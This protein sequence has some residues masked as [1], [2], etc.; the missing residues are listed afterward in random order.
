MGKAWTK[1][2]TKKKE[3]NRRYTRIFADK[4]GKG[5]LVK[6]VRGCLRAVF[7]YGVVRRGVMAA[8]S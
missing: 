7:W 1:R 4:V 2:T 6:L 3:M 8:S 5:G